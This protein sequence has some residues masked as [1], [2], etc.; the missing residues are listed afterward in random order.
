MLAQGSCHPRLRVQA[1][2]E[3]SPEPYSGWAG[4]PFCRLIHRVAAEHL[5][6]P[7]PVLS[8][9]TQAGDRLW[10]PGERPSSPRSLTAPASNIPQFCWE[11]GSHRAPR[12]RGD[13]VWSYGTEPLS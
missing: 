8:S 10:S 12:M 7:C 13:M 5:H 6:G 3:G 4:Q 2:E 9:R 11:A 1:A